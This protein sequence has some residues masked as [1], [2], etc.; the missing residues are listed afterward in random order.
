MTD[1][2]ESPFLPQ[3][4]EINLLD[5]LMV[6]VKRKRLVIGLPVI[7]AIL[8]ICYS[9]SLPNIY[10]ATAKI[11]P[12]Q[13]EGGGGGLSTLLSQAGGLAGLAGGISG[14][15]GPAEL[16]VGILKS[17]S[18]GDAV[19]KRLNLVQI[20][21]AKSVEDARRSL[22]GTVKIQSS[23]DG[24]I[25]ISADN[26]DSKLAAQLANSYV[27]E[28]ARTSIRLNLSKIGTERAFLEKRLDLV[29]GDLKTAEESLKTF[30]QKNQT[31][32]IDSQAKASIEGIAKLKAELATREVQL[33]SLRSYQTDESP[34]VKAL[35]STIAK[36]RKE[37][38]ANAA[39]SGSGEGIPGLGSVP[40]LGLQ[41]ARLMRELKTQEAVFEQLT[42]QYEIAKLS[43]AKD[44]TTIQVLDEAVP[45]LGKS[46]PKRSM[47]VILAAVSAFFVGIFCA[48]I[49][50]YLET[51]TDEDRMRLAKMKRLALSM[52]E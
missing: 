35:L 45:P 1:S 27:D 20:F 26:K 2:Q 3:E 21:K 52:R 18:V 39:A 8:S 17:R 22:E 37:I 12:P 42:K 29:R 6:I 19:V 13:K 11:L 51:L 7:A 34:E 48:F 4:E 38:G 40:G 28:L 14:L 32:Q 46:K 24:I 25:T 49:L 10:T 36:L 16:Y 5:L 23:K 33:E 47:I 30:A 15:S 31:I 44:S 9:L 41:Y 50:E 43:E